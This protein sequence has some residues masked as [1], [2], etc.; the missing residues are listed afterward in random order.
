MTRLELLEE[1]AKKASP[2]PW[3]LEDP[4]NH[5]WGMTAKNI[6]AAKGDVIHADDYYL[7]AKES[8]FVF[9]LTFSPETVLALIERIRILESAMKAP[10]SLANMKLNEWIGLH[11]KHVLQMEEERLKLMKVVRAARDFDN[12]LCEFGGWDHMAVR[13]NAQAMHDALSRLEE[14]GEEKA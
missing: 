9:I 14:G 11:D 4:M 13:D 6:I 3:E 1:I 7:D 12:A 8:D 2:G 5:H 10:N